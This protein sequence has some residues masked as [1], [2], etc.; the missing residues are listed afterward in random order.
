MAQLHKM[1]VLNCSWPFKIHQRLSER[2]TLDSNKQICISFVYT[3]TNLP[4]YSYEMAN[5]SEHD[6]A[7]MTSLVL[8]DKIVKAS[9]DQLQKTNLRKDPITATSA[10]LE[11]TKMILDQVTLEMH[12]KLCEFNGNSPLE[13]K[14]LNLTRECLCLT[15]TILESALKELRDDQSLSKTISQTALELTESILEAACLELNQKESRSLLEQK[16]LHVVA[17][18]QFLNQPTLE[19]RKSVSISQ[20]ALDM[21]QMILQ[22]AKWELEDEAKQLAATLAASNLTNA[23]LDQIKIDLKSALE[24]AAEKPVQRPKS[25]KLRPATAPIRH[26]KSKN[27]Q[28]EPVQ[29]SKQES[30]STRALSTKH[31]SDQNSHQRGEDSFIK[32]KGKEQKVKKGQDTFLKT[33]DPGQQERDLRQNNNHSSRPSPRYAKTS[34]VCSPEIH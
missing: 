10:A 30:K 23:I 17:S 22:E 2:K 26:Q 1:A 4:N 21:T 28:Q 6:L 32:R 20:A 24:T 13:K 8:T 19:N 15:E 16:A 27:S 14:T 7:I 34:P 18:L 33:G 5:L 25:A 11:L 29:H 3:Q 31:I 9:N 12:P